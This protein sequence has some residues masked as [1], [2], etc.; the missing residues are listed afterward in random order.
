MAMSKYLSAYVR[1]NQVKAPTL[2]TIVA[3]EHRKFRRK[4]E[5][6]EIK[7]VLYVKEF[8]QGIVLNKT[9]I[10]F[11]I[12]EYGTDDENQWIGRH[13]VVFFDPLVRNPDGVQVGGL[14]FRSAGEQ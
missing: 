14:R 3:V 4:D 11:F 8:E 7:A 10:R 12:E 1:A 9:A 5:P 2:V 13:A 6:E